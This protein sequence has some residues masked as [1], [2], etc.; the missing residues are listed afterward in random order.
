MFKYDSN[1]RILYFSLLLILFS[2]CTT[3]NNTSLKNT[4]FQDNSKIC[5]ENFYSGQLSTGLEARFNEELIG[6]IQFKIKGITCTADVKTEA[7]FSNDT[8]IARFD[9]INC[10]IDKTFRVK[11][12]LNDSEC[13]GS[14]IAKHIV[15][16]KNIEY[17]KKQLELYPWDNNFLKE[18]EKSQLGYLIVDKNT[19]IFVE[20]Y[21]PSIFMHKT[22]FNWNMLKNT[23]KL[24]K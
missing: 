3:K 1:K 11:G 8:I 18:Y 4:V 6:L 14:L 22:E 17:L 13:K 24:K 10:G 15:N 2:G 19:S 23:Q 21:E 20:I 9:T 16:E 7:V 5:N 12:F